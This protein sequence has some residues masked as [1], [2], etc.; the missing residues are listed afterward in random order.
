M[1][2]IIPSV[3]TAG[4]DVGVLVPVAVHFD[5]LDSMGL[6]HNGRYQ[7]LVERAWGEFWRARGIGGESGIEGDGFNVAKTFNI[8]YELPV[9]GVG[10]FAV[11]L[12][13]KRL[14][15]TSATAGYRV[16]SADGETTYAHGTRSVVRLDCTTLTPVPWSERVREIAR[17][18][19]LPE[20]NA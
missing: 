16:C 12:W 15:T 4:P 6:L 10:E 2:G 13:M 17:T 3:D 20:E 8:T 11:H 18:I 5:E 9:S 19:G 7:V 1:A 14:G